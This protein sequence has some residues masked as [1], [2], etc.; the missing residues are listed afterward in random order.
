MGQLD[1]QG[2]IGMLVMGDLKVETLV[3]C[4]TWGARHY[5]CV[6]GASIGLQEVMTT[7]QPAELTSTLGDLEP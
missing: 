2:N 3:V 1:V 4:G 6:C 7:Q 5:R